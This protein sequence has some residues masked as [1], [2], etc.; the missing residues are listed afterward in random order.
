VEDTD[1]L[2]LPPP[3]AVLGGVKGGRVRSVEHRRERREGIRE[4]EKKEEKERR[5]YYT[6]AAVTVPVKG[7]GSGIRA[8]RGAQ[9]IRGWLWT[10]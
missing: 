5:W 4:K 2:T 7:I 6:D 10:G 3:R 8:A 9:M 1:R